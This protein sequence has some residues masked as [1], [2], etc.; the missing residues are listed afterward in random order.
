MDNQA[1]TLALETSTALCR[2]AHAV[3]LQASEL[4]ALNR[5]RLREQAER[6]S[7]RNRRWIIREKLWDGRLPC[8]RPA[9]VRGGPGRGEM[10]AGCETITS[11]SQLVME[12]PGVDDEPLAYFHADCFQVWETLRR[13][14]VAHPEDRALVRVR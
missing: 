13:L 5:V 8:D 3:A 10:C 1:I 14:T 12:L 2:D 6:T 4:V 9:V 7:V 11:A